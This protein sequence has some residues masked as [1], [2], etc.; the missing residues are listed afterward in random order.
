MAITSVG[1][2]GTVNEAQWGALTTFLGTTYA[3]QGANDLAVTAN[4]GATL[5]CNIAAG[6]AFGYGILDVSSTAASVTFAT[7]V[8]GTRWD[9]VALRRDWTNPTPGGT[10]SFVVITGSATQ[11]VPTRNTTPGTLDEQPLALVQLTAGNPVP[12]AVVDLR[13]FASKTLTTAS[14]LALPTADRGVQAYVGASHYRRDYDST[15]NLAWLTDVNPLDATTNL[16]NLQTTGY[17]HQAT[18]ASAT[19]AL[20]YPTATVTGFLQVLSQPSGATVVL[21]RWTTT[22]TTLPRSFIRSLVGST[23]S[24]WLESVTLSDTGWVTTGFTAATGWTAGG[25][26]GYRII[27]NV[28]YLRGQVSRTT[29]Q[30]TITAPSTGNVPDTLILTIPTACRPA[31]TQYCNFKGT[32]TDGAV[33]V[34]TDGQIAL[35]SM[36]P[37]STIDPGDSLSFGTT[38]PLG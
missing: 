31:N 30:T 7:V 4:G 29:G 19:L 26:M 34:G 8:S 20:N 22:S 11:V 9:L 16:N 28:V 5:T 6:T 10:S 23:W 3:V 13:I 25:N 35:A 27:N 36:N 24:P 38:Y 1:Y 33:N 32:V 15:L 2:D 14:L 18:A 21:Q 17:Y 37:T 12:T